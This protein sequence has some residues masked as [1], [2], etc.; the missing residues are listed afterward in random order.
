MVLVAV[1]AVLPLVGCENGGGAPAAGSATSAPPAAAVA[2]TADLC[3]AWVDVDAI[4]AELL[5][6]RDLTFA[7]PEQVQ[8]VVKEVWSRQEPLLATMDRQAPAEIKPDTGKL[9]ELA[10]QGAA[11]G[12]VATFASP[13]LVAAD[14]GIDQY[15]LRECGYG[16]LNVDATD[17]G[18]QGVPDTTSAG[19]VAVS[20]RNRGQDAHQAVVSR[21]ADGVTE[22][23]P[24]I[25]ALPLDQQL[26]KATVLGMVQADPGGVDTVFLRLT[27]GRHGVVDLLPQGTTSVDAP[28]GG[29]PNYTVGLVA[30]FRVT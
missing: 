25:L 27:P 9:L 22:T 19:P 29:P 2:D 5:L 16:Q 14:R 12:D 28:G 8:E 10:R 20:L 21:A 11:A 17:Q 1:A 13:D 6:N 23:Y 7:S 30:E 26:Q 24:E 4:G 15:M 3:S 18:F